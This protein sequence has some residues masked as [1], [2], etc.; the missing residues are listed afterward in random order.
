MCGKRTFL[1]LGACNDDCEWMAGGLAR[2]LVKIGH[3]VAFAC[4][5]PREDRDGD[6][7]RTHEAWDIIGVHEKIVMPRPLSDLGDEELTCMV[8]QVIDRVQPDVCFIQPADDYMAHHIR[9]ARACW[10]ALMPDVR[11]TREE[12]GHVAAADCA[13]VGEVC[14]M[15]C[16]SA[17]YT[18]VDF[19]VNV[20]EE[21][22]DALRALR[23][24]DKWREGFGSGMAKTKEGL[25]TLRGVLPV[26]R[27]CEY[28]EGFKFVKIEETRI[29]CLPEVLGDRFS[30]YPYPR[31]FGPPA[32]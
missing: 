21:L 17:P 12:W 13:R 30:A 8:G 6:L 26:S 27:K 2:L 1:F 24:Y 11:P 25:A 16:P 28:A 5:A 14:A 32:Y 19:F 18:R 10:R 20:T 31:G 23:V 7:R 4:T 22:P 3:G 15:E 9:F 29:S